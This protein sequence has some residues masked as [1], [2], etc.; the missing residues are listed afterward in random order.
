MTVVIMN[1]TTQLDIAIQHADELQANIT[2][3]TKNKS[4]KQRLVE[5]N[6]R[7]PIFFN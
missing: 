7:T 2:E 4:T 3:S 1:F 6:V 5:F